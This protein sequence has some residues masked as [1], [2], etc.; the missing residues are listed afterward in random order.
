MYRTNGGVR[1]SWAIRQY[2]MRVRPMLM[3][4]NIASFDRANT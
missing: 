1:G 3:N 4:F 2:R